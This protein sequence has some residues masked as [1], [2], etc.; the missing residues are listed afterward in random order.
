ML[1]FAGLLAGCGGHSSSQRP[2]L[3]SYINQVNAIEKQLQQPFQ[4]VTDAGSQFASSNS[5]GK[6]KGRQSASALERK[7]QHALAQ[8]R[9]DGRH[10]A[11]IPPPP[12]AV[13][14]HTLLIQLVHGEAGMTTELARLIYFLPR[15]SSILSSLTPATGKLQ[16]ALR[17]TQPLG[18][19]AAGV[20]AEL[21]VKAKALHT[22]EQTLFVTIKRLRRL[23]PPALSQPQF[24]T[25]IK[26]LE[27]MQ[28]SAGK[29]ANGLAGGGSNVPALLGAFDRAAAGNQTVAAQRAQIAAIKA[30]DAKAATLDKL[31]K[32][33]ELER[34][35]LDRNLK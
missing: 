24:V 34:I 10:L 29:L 11:Q 33:V 2:A 6:G 23:A 22:Y 13:H 4:A 7:L 3:A 26:T 30:Y 9:A 1:A 16:A 5:A 14:L 28:A 32:A 25:Q 35:R 21:A 19:G 18:F 12:V 8:I 27:R 20:T 31:A 15:F 17:V